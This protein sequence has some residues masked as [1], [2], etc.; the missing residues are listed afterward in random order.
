MALRITCPGC[1]TAM[2]LDDDM[3]G[4]KVRCEKCDK[5]L[6]V[7]GAN[8]KK[9]KDDEAVQEGRKLKN[10]AAKAEEEELQDEEQEEERPAKKKK[11][12]KKKNSSSM[13]LLIGGG[14]AIAVL[15]IVVVGASAYFLT[16]SPNVA[17]APQNNEQLA[18]AND[19]KGGDG[20]AGD[21]KL[22]PKVAP[23]PL[24]VPVDPDQ[25]KR[26]KEQRN[27]DRAANKGGKSFV[28]TIRGAGARTQ[29]KNELRQIGSFYQQFCLTTPKSART[30]EAFLEFIKRDSRA[31]HEAISD[32]YYTIN[33]RADD[34]SSNSIIA[35][36][37]FIDGNGMYMAVRGDL[38]VDYVPPQDV[39][40]A[41]GK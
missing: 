19:K 8:G 7:P 21:K 41:M 35:F 18:K 34:A 25:A 1:K 32:D 29:R 27:E 13:G 33:F 40:N 39:K 11:K 37:S 26:E 24:P 9:H 17:K 31:I 38:S 36:E 10:A 4:R 2:K 14:A 12:K 30:K 16:R 22:D 23:A 15:L 3:R 6:N 28:G 5:T 20:G